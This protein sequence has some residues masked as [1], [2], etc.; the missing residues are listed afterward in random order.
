MLRLTGGLEAKFLRGAAAIFFVALAVRFFFV[1]YEMVWNDHGFMTGVDYVDEKI[2]LPLQWMSIVACVIAA[3][4]VG[5]GRWLFEQHLGPVEQRVGLG[6][7]L[8]ALQD[9][10]LAE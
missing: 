6:V 4:L 2:A 3:G 8:L 5:A 10:G 1:R 7:I 9:L